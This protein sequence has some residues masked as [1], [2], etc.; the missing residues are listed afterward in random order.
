M[1]FD[2]KRFP[3]TAEFVGRLP[4]GLDSYPECRIKADVFDDLGARYPELL[5]G[6]GMPPIVE[7]YLAGS[8]DEAWLPEAV[9]NALLMM[10]RDALFDSDSG[11]LDWCRGNMRSLF[12]KPLYKL[13]M[14]VFSTS[15]VVMGSTKRWSAFH[16]GTTL[17]ASPIR[18]VEGR[19]ET[20][21]VLRYPHHLFGG[22]LI[23][24]LASTY[25]AAF[26]VNKAGEPRVIPKEKNSTESL[27]FVSWKA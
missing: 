9:S 26:D 2:R 15:L 12:E 21:G 16:E 11:F 1:D 7:R 5:S 19:Y 22:L 14:H 3:L 25:L 6:G 23:E 20:V 4:E 18:K 8:Y 17:E 24:Q 10:V 13:M 27:F